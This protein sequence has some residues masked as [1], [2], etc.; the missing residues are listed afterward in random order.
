MTF[1]KRKGRI[2]TQL[3]IVNRIFPN[4]I[5]CNNLKPKI[6]NTRSQ[7]R[8]HNLVDLNGMVFNVNNYDLK[9]K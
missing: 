8:A 6:M 2:N 5:F 7:K 3:N 4:L 1:R 9:R